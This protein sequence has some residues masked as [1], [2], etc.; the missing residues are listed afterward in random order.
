MKEKEMNWAQKM[1]IPKLDF[2]KG[3]FTF[4][5]SHPVSSRKM[6]REWELN[7]EGRHPKIALLNPFYDLTEGTQEEI[8]DL[9]AGREVKKDPGYNWRLVQRDK[10]AIEFSRGILGIVDENSA[11]SIGTIMEFVYGRASA[12]N[13]KLLICT[14]EKLRDHPWLK[15]HFHK[16]YP[17][18]EAFEEDVEKQVARVKK[19]WGF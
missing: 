1:K 13:P 16:I 11:S 18:F 7:F 6:I 9:D 10:I 19:K 3:L 8:Q 15:T 12:C 17:S 2:P 5:L 14:N 4:Y